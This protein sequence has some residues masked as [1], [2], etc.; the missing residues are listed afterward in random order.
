[1]FDDEHHYKDCDRSHQAA[2]AALRSFRF[3]V[4]FCFFN[5]N[6]SFFDIMMSLFHIVVDSVQN[7]SLL[8]HQLRKVLEDNSQ[9]FDG[10]DQAVDFV[11]PMLRN[12]V[13]LLF[14]HL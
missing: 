6:D 4:G 5:I 3:F 9:V 13:L 1:M 11:T 10:R 8:Y 7:S 12:V 14:K 2:N